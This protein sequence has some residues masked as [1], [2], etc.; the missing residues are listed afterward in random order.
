MPT[1]TI[2]KVIAVKVPNASIGEYVKVTNLTK[3]GSYYS[4]LQGGD[5]N[6]NISQNED[7]T[8][9]NEDDIQAEIHGRLDGYARTKIQSGGAS[10]QITAT[11]DTSTPGAD[12]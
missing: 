8:W 4:K 7:F 6:T 5:R 9:E 3:G 1:P 12:L 2:Q 11:A 10:V